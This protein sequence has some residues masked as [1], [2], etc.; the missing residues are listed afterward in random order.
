MSKKIL[1]VLSEWGY[2][3]EELIGPLDVFDEKGYTYDF[4]TPTGR[5]PRALPPSMSTDFTDPPLGKSVTAADMAAKV[6]KIDEQAAEFFK[7][8]ISLAERFPLRPYL[9][10]A[11]QEHDERSLVAGKVPVLRLLEDYYSERE[12]AR[13][14]AAEEYDAILLVGGSGPMVDMVN[15][16]RLHDLVL[17]F[18]FADK[19]VAAECYGVACLAQAREFDDC[20]SILWGKH[21]TGHAKEYDYTNDTGVLD[22]LAPGQLLVNRDG[23]FV[24]FG[25]PFYTLEFILRDAVGPE[26]QFHGNFGRPT[27]VLVD[28]PF[29]TGRSTPDAYLT[30]RKLVEVLETG[31]R[32]FG[33][34]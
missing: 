19:P 14:R 12:T 11:H 30:A 20:R 7:G 21:V 8:V 5:I 15:N 33:W 23:K 26:G 16:R 2:W 6:K 9:S 31:L 18:Y 4:W 13:A 28:Y 24:N 22:P 34:N 32:R 1:I 29:I 25:P 17:G 3:G 27:S 10:E